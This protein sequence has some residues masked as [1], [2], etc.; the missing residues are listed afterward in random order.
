MLV[1]VAPGAEVFPVA[2]VRGVVV[3]V[4]V[5][6]VDSKEVEVRQIELPAT[7][8]T[9]PAMELQRTLPIVLRP[10]LIGLQTANQFIQLFLAFGRY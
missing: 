4:T 7:F 2:P 9:D 10:R 6:V 8:G 1:V 5:A 3:V